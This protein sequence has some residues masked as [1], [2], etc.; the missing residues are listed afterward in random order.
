M[1]EPLTLEAAVPEDLA[2]LLAIERASYSHPWSEASLRQ[3]VT[4]A[5]RF[6][7]LVLRAPGAEAEPD[8]GVR[9][10]CIFQLVADELHVHNVAVAAPW[11]GGGLARRLLE[12]AFEV[13]RSG[14]ARR[15]FL[16]VRESNA[17][18]R[19]LYSALGFEAVGHRRDYYRDPGEDA[20]VLQ[21]ELS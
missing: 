11:R 13:G 18:A 16:E 8:R 19:A 9:G 4:Q 17:A 1:S 2:A 3:A 14:G 20:L 21:R 10:Y 15:A 6:G 5:R 12:R 7:V